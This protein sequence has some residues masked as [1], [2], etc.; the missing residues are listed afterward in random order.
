MINP[1]TIGR[2]G[3]SREAA[4]AESNNR[5][6]SQAMANNAMAGGKYRRIKGGASSG[7]PVSQFFVVETSLVEP[8]IPTVSFDYAAEKRQMQKRFIGQIV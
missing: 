1:T 3:T 7:I 6:A 4:I 8:R 5:A 2:V